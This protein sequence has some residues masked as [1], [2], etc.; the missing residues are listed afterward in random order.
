MAAAAPL[1]ALVN[2]HDGVQIGGVYTAFSKSKARATP[3]LAP[4]PLGLGPFHQRL[5]CTR[6]GWR[7]AVGF[8]AWGTGDENRRQ[9]SAGCQYG[10]RR[11]PSRSTWKEMYS[12]FHTALTGP[13]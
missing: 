10:W 11:R 3:D 5:T 12:T 1:P 8:E 7:A 13:E 6:W 4:G 2:A 9:V